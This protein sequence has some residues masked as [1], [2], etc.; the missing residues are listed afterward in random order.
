MPTD[1]FAAGFKR[2]LKR[3]AGFLFLVGVVVSGWATYRL[4][5]NWSPFV[6]KKTSNIDVFDLSATP[7]PLPTLTPV[8]IVTPS[9][10]VTLSIP[11]IGDNEKN[12]LLWQVEGFNAS[13][14]QAI[15]LHADS[16]TMVAA[17]SN[18]PPDYTSPYTPAELPETR[19]KVE[20]YWPKEMPKDGSE[21]VVLILQNKAAAPIAPSVSVGGYQ[22][23]TGSPSALPQ[24]P[25][26][27]EY[28]AYASAALNSTNFEVLP[29]SLEW[30]P[31][32]QPKTEWVW[33]VRAKHDRPVHGQQRL[34]TAIKV[35]L[36]DKTGKAISEEQVWQG[37]AQ[38][39]VYDKWISKDRV[40]ITSLVS[41]FVGAGIS[42][43][44]I[45]DRL[46]E[47]A[48]KKKRAQVSRRVVVKV[49]RRR[50][51]RRR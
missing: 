16:A 29:N 42:V 14:R 31:L 37:E 50:R 10:L 26:D 49:P 3:S 41:L 45:Y 23:T 24:R 30:Q 40:N 8:P 28:E 5:S 44:W 48:E 13:F 12:Q 19:E 46:K 38:I 21:H 4:I 47:R 34:N 39:E 7:S 27:A 22:S 18:R 35:Q 36:R 1:G 25:P 2:Q 15:S 11:K 33:N 43:P 20:T 9:P 17:S 32:K 51:R 6:Y